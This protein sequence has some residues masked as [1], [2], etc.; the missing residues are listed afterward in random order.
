MVEPEAERPEATVPWNG[1]EGVC[2]DPEGESRHGQV[3]AK[4]GDGRHF[5]MRMRNQ[6]KMKE[7]IDGKAP[8]EEGAEIQSPKRKSDLGGI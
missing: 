7:Q 3:R 6:A 4:L 1:V 8:G 5:V 2:V